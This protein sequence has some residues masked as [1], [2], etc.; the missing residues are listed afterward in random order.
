MMST[1][2]IVPYASPDQGWHLTLDC[3]N[4]PLSTLLLLLL[5]PHMWSHPAGRKADIWS[6]GCTVV[7]MLTGKHPWPEMDNQFTAMMTINNTRT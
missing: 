5:L 1:G 3:F 4:E 6:L 2:D 7:E